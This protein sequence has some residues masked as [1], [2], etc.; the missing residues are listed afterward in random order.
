MSK[1]KAVDDKT[2]ANLDRSEEALLEHL[3]D[4][5][6]KDGVRFLQHFPQPL[7]QGYRGYCH[8]QNMLRLRMVLLG[9]IAVCIITGVTDYWLQP[10]NADKLWELRAPVLAIW[11]ALLV[12]SFIVGGGNRFHNIAGLLAI[13]ALTIFGATCAAASDRSLAFVYYAC[14]P[15][16]VLFSMTFSQILFSWSA[17]AMGAMLLV[18][19][20]YA[21]FSGDY[22][23]Q[24]VL[25]FNLTL[26]LTSI[27]G[28]VNVFV[29]ESARRDLY[30]QIQHNH[31]VKIDPKELDENR[32]RL[33][34]LVALDALTGIANK[35][36]FDR[37]LKLEW[38]RAARQ[39]HA[40]SLVMVDID[41][42]KEF[43]K[44]FGRKTGDIWLQKIAVET[45]RFAR[46]PG[47]IAARYTDDSFVI[48]L[49]ETEAANAN[50][51][52]ESLLKNV[53]GINQEMKKG[54]VSGVVTSVSVSIGIATMVPSPKH[55]PADI[56]SSSIYALNQARKMGSGRVYNLAAN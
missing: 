6:R 33:R 12:A 29:S 19:N 36:S 41:N 56:V 17:I 43:N 52:A 25:G 32:G 18:A 49:A 27:I 11:T 2:N 14:V 30:L 55:F 47:D 40:I 44:Q 54:S 35:K 10:L 23:W 7:E 50:L 20:A 9:L 51:V 16:L 26:L 37:A 31:I 13:V 4:R 39:K 53:E 48:M 5:I 24:Q 34:F 15:M 21:L 22:Q 8:V 3:S 38:D 42:F 28:L 45:K 1:L 46:R